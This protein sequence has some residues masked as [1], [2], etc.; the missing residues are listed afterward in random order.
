M[1]MEIKQIKYTDEKY[2]KQLKLIQN[3]PKQL[4][5]MGNENILENEGRA[6]IG[7][8]CCTEYGAQYATKFAKE[9]AKQEE[10]NERE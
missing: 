3:P 8:R 5:I 4:Y 6:I 7:S 1:Q 9:L 10:Q 2:P